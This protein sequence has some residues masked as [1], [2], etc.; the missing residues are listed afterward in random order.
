MNK[1][2]TAFST[3]LEHRK[4][5]S[6]DAFELSCTRPK[7]FH[8]RSGQHIA[9]NIDGEERD[10]TI[11]SPENSDK[12]LL[13]VKE[14][15]GG[16]VSKKLAQIP[17]G[18]ELQMSGPGGYLV[19]RPT[20]KQR[21]LVATGTGIAPFVSM[22][23]NGMEAALLLHGARNMEELYYR[24]ILEKTI[25]KYIPCLSGEP[26]REESDFCYDGYVTGYIRDLLPGGEYE[27]YLCGKW[28]MIKDVT[29]IIDNRFPDSSVY[30]EGFY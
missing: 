23:A 17:V 3:T 18:K 5:F 7:G 6:S 14:L 22:L 19:E 24:H 10:Y 28:D 2:N 13:L 29:H 1:P 11:V 15:E 8:F 27:F 16:K 26:C 4:W 21:V 20:D 9:L 25:P 12:L 30:S